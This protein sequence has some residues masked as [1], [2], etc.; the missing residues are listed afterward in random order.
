[1]VINHLSV[2]VLL[3]LMLVNYNLSF[4]AILRFRNFVIDSKVELKANKTRN[5]Q[6]NKRH[7][8]IFCSAMKLHVPVLSILDA[9]VGK[10][11]IY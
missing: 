6:N 5:L 10:G 4:K 8:Q 1:M 7:T 11:A 9:T 3:N 2:L